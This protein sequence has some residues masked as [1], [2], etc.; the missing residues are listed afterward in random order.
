[1]LT[2]DFIENYCYKSIGGLALSTQLGYRSSIDRY[3][4]PRF[5]DIDLNDITVLMVESWLSDIPSN[6][7]ALK[8]YKTLRQIIRKACDYDMYF[9]SDPTMKHIKAP[10]TKGYSPYVLNAKEVKLLLDGFRGHYLEPTVICSVTLG[11]RRGEAFALLWEDIDFS[12]GAVSISKS[13]QNVGGDILVLPTKTVKSTR[14]C[15]FPRFACDRLREIGRDKSGR[16]SGCDI[17]DP[18]KMAS[19]YK[20]HCMA[21]SL[22]FTSFTNLRHTWATLALES[23]ADIS[24][25]ANMLGHT[26]ISTTYNHYIKPRESVYIKTQRNIEKLIIG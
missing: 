18:N 20:K 2:K 9:G 22:P 14:S 25:V 6:G 17:V 23:G 4:L 15:V 7:A 3:I 26:D 19:D 16:I 8:A 5:G 24:T 21:N 11:L 12:S 10:R 13:Y 1:M